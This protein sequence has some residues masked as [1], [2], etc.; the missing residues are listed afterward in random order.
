LPSVE[1][2]PK[3]FP[4]H[5]SSIL[6]GGKGEMSK[7]SMVTREQIESVVR[8]IYE[9]E[10]ARPAHSVD[11]TITAIDSVMA[12]GVEGWSNSEHRPNR[13]AERKIER[14]LFEFLDDYHREIERVVID[15]PL[16]SFAW[17]IRSAKRNLDI[18]GCS[19]LEVNE[20]G[21]LARYWIYCDPAPLAAMVKQ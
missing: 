2:W 13:S 16:V 8:R 15:P 21:L 20:A 9:I 4:E 5:F 11:E 10:N 6:T 18:P 7:T 19:M 12:Q 17:R 14:A 3:I 1:Y